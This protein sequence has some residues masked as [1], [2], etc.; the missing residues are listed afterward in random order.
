MKH[1]RAWGLLCLA[2]VLAM[3]VQATFSNWLWAGLAAQQLAIPSR[4]WWQ[5]D[6]WAHPSN[7]RPIALFV[8]TILALVTLPSLWIARWTR[9]SLIERLA[10]IAMTAIVGATLLSESS[11][12]AHG[13]PWTLCLLEVL[14]GA[15]L[16]GW[17]A[18]RL[19]PRE[20]WPVNPKAWVVVGFFLAVL[21][22]SLDGTQYRLLRTVSMVMFLAPIWATPMLAWRWPKVARGIGALLIAFGF[23]L[24][25]YQWPSEPWVAIV[26]SAPFWLAGL[27]HVSA[28]SWGAS[29]A[30]AATA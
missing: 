17:A 28:W 24:V 19:W 3:A 25:A 7:Y 29:R 27:A 2:A 5:E 12:G 11:G 10:P 26:L 21:I 13:L 4:F 6:R 22:G 14:P 20:A 18:Q 15:S 1:A 8:L 9:R 30:R 16:L 23:G